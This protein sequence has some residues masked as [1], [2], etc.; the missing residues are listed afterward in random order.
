MI[1]TNGAEKYGSYRVL[2][3]AAAKRSDQ[4]N[5]GTLLIMAIF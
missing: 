5:E 1:V 4:D 2:A 3:A